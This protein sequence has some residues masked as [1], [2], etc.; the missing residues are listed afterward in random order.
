MVTFAVTPLH[1]VPVL[2]RDVDQGLLFFLVESVRCGGGPAV[3]AGAILILQIDSVIGCLLVTDRAVGRHV[4]LRT[5]VGGEAL[6]ILTAALELVLRQGLEARSASGLRLG[7]SRA[8]ASSVLGLLGVTTLI[9]L[10]SLL[11]LIVATLIGLTVSIAAA[12]FASGVHALEVG[13]SV[14]QEANEFSEAGGTRAKA[15]SGNLA[16]IAIVELVA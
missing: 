14:L 4:L 7:V 3:R 15:E 2:N 12:R 9:G 5:A 10:L 6:A 1:V 16:L 11:A 8:G 13:L